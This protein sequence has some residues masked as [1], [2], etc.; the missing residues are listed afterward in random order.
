MVDSAEYNDPVSGNLL[1][2]GLTEQPVSMGTVEAFEMQTSNFKPSSDAPPA[3]FVNLVAK[4]GGNEWYGS[5]YYLLQNHDAHR[6]CPSRLP[7]Q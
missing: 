6:H 5:A 2:R 4:Q 7:D 1:G 3:P